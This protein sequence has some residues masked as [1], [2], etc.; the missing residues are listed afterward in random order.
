MSKRRVCVL[1]VLGLLGC[2][3]LYWLPA[4][5]VEGLSAQ[6]FRLL[7]M[8]QPTLL[9]IASVLVGERYA[10]RTGMGTR[11]GSEPMTAQER[12]RFARHAALCTMLGVMAGV[13]SWAAFLAWKPMLP[14]V[15]L[16]AGAKSA[17]PLMVRLLYGS[18]AEELMMRWGLMSWLLWRLSRRSQLP[19]RPISPAAKWVAV[20]TVAVVFG[21]AHL[22]L[23]FQLSGGPSGVVASFVVSANLPLGI[24]A[25]L[26]FAYGGLEL[27]MVMHAAAG[28]TMFWLG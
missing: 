6:Q 12:E 14:Q 20:L 22:P 19:E 16:A 10:P 7:R 28:I 24:A 2:S 25:G 18:L 13:A 11:L 5:A 1:G 15:F 23:A 8:V 26:A 27:A 17:P 3:S 9:T 4:D 21:A